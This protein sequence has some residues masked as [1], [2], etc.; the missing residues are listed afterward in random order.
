MLRFEHALGRFRGLG[1]HELRLPD[2]VTAF[3]ALAAHGLQRTYAAFVAGAARLDA[4]ADPDLLLGELAVELGVRLRLV[5]ELQRLA[6][7]V[8]V[9][10]PGPRT[11]APAV[12]LDHA[13]REAVDEGA[14]VAHEQQ[15]AAEADQRL[16][17]PLDGPDVQMVGGL[18]EQQDVGIADERAREQ[19]APAPT[20]RELREAALTVEPEPRHD[21]GDA[22][23]RLPALAGVGRQPAAHDVHHQTV[24]HRIEV[25]RER[26]QLRTRPEPHGA[27]IGRGGARDQTQ[28]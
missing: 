18:V 28:Q 21:G 26:R 7:H 15:R 17:E 25:L 24:V 12:E 2:A 16:L 3:A 11:Q 23:L 20:A 9:V 5:L 13:R 19:R 1:E 10:V 14:I 4:L 6:H 8:V 27:V 22:V